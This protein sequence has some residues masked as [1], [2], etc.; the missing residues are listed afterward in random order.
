MRTRIF[1]FEQQ[2]AL[3]LGLAINE[4]L[5]LDY[6]YNFMQSGR[7]KE[8]TING[9]KYYKISYSKLIEDLPII[10]ESERSFRRMLLNLEKLQIIKKI[11]C[12]RSIYI[13]INDEILFGHTCPVN[14]KIPDKFCHDTGQGLQT[15]DYYDIKKIKINCESAHA[16]NISKQEFLELFKQNIANLTSEIFY[17]AF[18]KNR[19]TLDEVGKDYFIFS[20]SNVKAITS[21]NGEKFRSAFDKTISDVLNMQTDSN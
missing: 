18:I 16:I 11:N 21:I 9:I 5:L 13:H 17:E 2:V 4:L 1:I 15:I 3:R 8:V 10:A 6:L 7:M 12:N 14:S 20:A 19:L